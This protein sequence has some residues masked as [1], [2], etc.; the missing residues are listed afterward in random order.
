MYLY[1]GTRRNA[2][3]AK[4][5][6]AT[7]S[8]SVPHAIFVTSLTCVW[9]SLFFKSADFHISRSQLEYEPSGTWRSQSLILS[10]G[11]QRGL[12]DIPDTDRP[13]GRKGA[14][15]KEKGTGRTEESLSRG[16]SAVRVCAYY[17]RTGSPVVCSR[18]EPLNISTRSLVYIYIYITSGRR[19]SMTT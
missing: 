19:P 5:K 10:A 18:R 14:R 1:K 17:I 15:E 9:V 11:E 6:D 7:L 4:Q 3:E 12:L 16:S 8:T 2:V 13:R